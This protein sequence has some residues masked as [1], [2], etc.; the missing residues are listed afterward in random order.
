MATEYFRNFPTIAYGGKQAKNILLRAAL[1]EAIK[2]YNTVFLPLT[3]EPGERPDMIA[4]DL[5][6]DAGYDW[7]VR[8]SNSDVI[9]PYFDWYLTDELVEA[10]IIKKYGSVATAIN[11]VL[12]YKNNT[13]TDIIINVDT[14]TLM[15]A[16]DKADYSAVS[17]YE[18]ET[19]L[20]L[21]HRNIAVLR[22]SD[23]QDLDNEL[24]KKL[25]A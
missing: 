12:H 9:D 14:Y 17:A 22:P 21:S 23:V 11:T 15:S 4:S 13:N 5:Y 20:N 19:D 3:I 2:K 1:K 8:F 16:I 6:K 18:Y 7:V 10:K 25:N 24:E